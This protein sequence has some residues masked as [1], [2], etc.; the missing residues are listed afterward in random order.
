[1]AHPLIAK[2]PAT[3]IAVHLVLCKVFSV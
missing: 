1:V 3:T 2:T